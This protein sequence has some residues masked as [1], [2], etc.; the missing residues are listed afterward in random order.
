[1]PNSEA[2]ERILRKAL[3]TQDLPPIPAS[4]QNAWQRPRAEAGAKW[5]WLLPAVIFVLGLAVGSVLAPLGL[6]SAV[7]SIASALTDVWRSLPENTVSWARALLTGALII[8]FDSFRN[9]YSR[10]K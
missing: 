4:I 10:L 8:A 9:L 5:V 2:F 1:M 3:Q 6:G 7:A